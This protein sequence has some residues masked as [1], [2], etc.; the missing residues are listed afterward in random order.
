[1]SETLQIWLFAGSFSAIVALGVGINLL[2]IQMTALQTTQDTLIKFLGNKAAFL[3]HSPHTPELDA[4]IDKFRRDHITDTEMQEFINML[5]TIEGDI[6]MA[7]GERLLASLVLL[8]IER[9]DTSR[10]KGFNLGD[11]PARHKQEPKITP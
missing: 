4:L 3:L 7:K 10:I 8:A 2:K 6:T 1:M 9:I 5:L 11:A